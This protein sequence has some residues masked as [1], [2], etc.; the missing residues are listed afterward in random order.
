MLKSGELVE[1]R[2]KGL[3]MQRDFYLAYHA[4]RHLFP[5][6]RYFIEFIRQECRL[7]A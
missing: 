2:V 3:D 4:R 6:A 5:A 1:I 7:G